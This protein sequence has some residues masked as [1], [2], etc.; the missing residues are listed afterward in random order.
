MMMG[1]ELNCEFI[2]SRQYF[3]TRRD[4]PFDGFKT[5]TPDNYTDIHIEGLRVDIADKE[6][7]HDEKG[8]PQIL[9]GTKATIRLFG[10]GITKNTLITFTDMPAERGVVCDKI[11]SKE[12][13]V[14]I[15]VRVTQGEK[16]CEKKAIKKTVKI[17]KRLITFNI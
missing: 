16:V 14:S 11:K 4:D 8:I 12:F 1:N 6:P 10:S 9:A 17:I 7:S 2:I 13:P 5:S 3:R 15:A